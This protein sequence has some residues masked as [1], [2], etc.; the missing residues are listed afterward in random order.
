MQRPR[1]TRD[2]KERSSVSVS[3][4]A[5]I[6]RLPMDG[7]AAQCGINPQ[8]ISLHSFLPMWRTMTGIVG[9]VWSGATLLLVVA[10]NIN[11]S[12]GAQGDPV[13]VQP[14]RPSAFPRPRGQS[15]ESRVE[16]RDTLS[17]RSHTDSRQR[18]HD[19][20]M[21]ECPESNV[22]RG[23]WCETQ[24]FLQCCKRALPA[25]PRS[26]SHGSL[27][28]VDQLAASSSVARHQRLFARLRSRCRKAISGPSARLLPLLPTWLV[29]RS[30]LSDGCWMPPAFWLERVRS[31]HQWL[32]AQPPALP[33]EYPSQQSPRAGIGRVDPYSAIRSRIPPPS[34]TS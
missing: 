13:P 33:S 1:L 12:S 10:T 32:Y 16:F 19:V 9:E 30:V 3:A 22:R 28:E 15:R 7:S 31:P 6:I 20:S 21:S 25:L 11:H 14:S 23:C 34:E 29:P 27:Q 4:R 8:C 24:S 17:R 26:S 2:L 18:K 5:L